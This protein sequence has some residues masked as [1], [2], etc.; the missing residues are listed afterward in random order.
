MEHEG[1]APGRAVGTRTVVDLCACASAAIAAPLLALP[2]IASE[3]TVGKV[4][5]E[6]IASCKAQSKREPRA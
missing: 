5:V 6:K 4:R 2:D 3:Q 1:E